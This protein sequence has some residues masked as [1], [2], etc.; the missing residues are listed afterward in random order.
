MSGNAM[1]TAEIERYEANQRTA[2]G[3]AVVEVMRILALKDAPDVHWLIGDD[4]C[5][6]LFQRIFEI[7]P[8]EMLQQT[9]LEAARARYW[10]HGQAGATRAIPRDS[11]GW[12]PPAWW[13]ANVRNPPEFRLD[14]LCVPAAEIGTTA[15][16]KAKRACLRRPFCSPLVGRISI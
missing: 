8:R 6:C 16:R 1:T 4:L 3:P 5:E 7:S 10:K 13:A 14:L 11:S 2:D 15:S 12:R 9:R